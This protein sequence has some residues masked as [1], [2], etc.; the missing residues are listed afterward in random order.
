MIADYLAS[1][2]FNLPLIDAVNDPDLPGVRSEIAAVALGEDLDAGYY[3]VQEL[4]DAFLEAARE[5][6]AEITDPRSPAR[7]HLAEILD[8]A[9]S[10]QRGLFNAVAKLPLIDAASD[11]V[12]LTGLMRD[13]ADMYRPVEAARLS[14]R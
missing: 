3:E 8:R 12:W 2:D 4:A 11:L 1:F 7:E 5:A 14:T 9:S 10:Y 13:R 6:N